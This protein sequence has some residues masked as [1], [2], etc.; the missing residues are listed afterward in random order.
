M[1]PDKIK[2]GCL[3]EKGVAEVKEMPMP[4]LLADEI[5]VKQDA[6]NINNGWACVSTKAIPWQAVT[7]VRERSW[8]KVLR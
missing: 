7:N 5:L 6:C 3:V 4:E 8:L 1:I 2:F